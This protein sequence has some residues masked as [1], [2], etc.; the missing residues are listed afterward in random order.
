MNRKTTVTNK[1]PGE[2]FS[3]VHFKTKNKKCRNAFWCSGTVK[4]GAV[5]MRQQPLVLV[6]VNFCLKF[7]FC[8]GIGDFRRIISV[9]AGGAITGSVNALGNLLHA[10][11]A[12]VSQ[13]V[14]ADLFGDFR[15]GIFACDEIFAGI[16][17]RPVKAGIEEG[18]CA[19]ESLSHP[20]PA[21]V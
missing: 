3:V 17:V 9:E 4:Q 1:M 10:L 11:N 13:R 2:V 19:C 14:Y 8:R 18:R 5:A 15:N 6:F 21:E 16:N 12:Q 7:A 20:P